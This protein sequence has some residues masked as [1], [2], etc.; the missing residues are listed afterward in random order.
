[1]P[2]NKKLMYKNKLI[3]NWLMAGLLLLVVGSCGQNGGDQK[4]V[5]PKVAKLKLPAGFEA[6]HLYSPGE[7][8][9]GSWVGMTFDDKNRLLTVDQYGA[10][11]RMEVPPIS[12]DSL[13]PAVEKLIIGESGDNKIGMGYAQ[14]LLYAFNSLYVMVNHRANDDFDKSTGMYRLQDTN[15]DDQFDQIEGDRQKLIGKIEENYGIARDEAEKQVEEW[16][17]KTHK[18]AA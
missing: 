11:Y 13:T 2:I 10:I 4:E 5:D 7:N 14:A 6:E 17:Q 15:G 3:R 16:E 9:Q 18:E 8:E 1:M 12:S